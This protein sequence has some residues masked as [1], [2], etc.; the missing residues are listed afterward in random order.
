MHLIALEEH[1]VM[2]DSVHV[3]RWHSTA[4]N[5]VAVSNIQREALSWRDAQRI[6]KL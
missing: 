4:S 5:A 1:F 6:L 3:D 2:D